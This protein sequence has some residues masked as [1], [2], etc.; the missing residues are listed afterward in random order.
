MHAKNN[1]GTLI[2]SPKA[3]IRGSACGH[4]TLNFWAINEPNGTPISPDVIP[5]NPNLYATLKHFE[6][7]IRANDLPNCRCKIAGDQMRK[8][9]SS[10]FTLFP[11]GC[12]ENPSCKNVGAHQASAPVT[13]ATHVNPTVESIKLGLKRTEKLWMEKEIWTVHNLVVQCLLSYF[14]N[15]AFKS[16]DH[17]VLVKWAPPSLSPLIGSLTNVS[18]KIIAT[19]PNMGVTRK[20]HRQL[21]A[22]FAV[23]APVMYPKPL[24]IKYTDRYTFHTCYLVHR[25]RALHKWWNLSSPSHWYCKVE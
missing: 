6:T 16:V 2:K 19:T 25:E 20:P 9:Y 15:K 11:L 23:S 21:P 1:N 17:A 4:R 5:I 13:N 7:M 22:A 10:V 8:T 12:N 18:K 24:E 3:H 14:F